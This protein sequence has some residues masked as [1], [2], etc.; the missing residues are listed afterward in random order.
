MK[1]VFFSFA[2]IFCFTGIHNKINQKI[3][4]DGFPCL[5]FNAV[6]I[7]TLSY[8]DFCPVEIV[9]IFALIKTV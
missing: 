9:Q 4:H 3:I 5:Y 2:K 1:T 8:G 6:I 7:S